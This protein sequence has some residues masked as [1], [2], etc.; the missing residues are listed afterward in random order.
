M[1]H[2]D[3]RGQS[4][5][6]GVTIAK[7]NA[8]LW[9]LTRRAVT[10]FCCRKMISLE[11]EPLLN[12]NAPIIGGVDSAFHPMKIHIFSYKHLTVIASN[13]AMFTSRKAMS[14]SHHRNI[15]NFQ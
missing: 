5:L 11:F 2:I 8:M 6:K 4:S 3:F 14:V 15:F 7:L 10:L 13:N 1:K 9:G 12:P